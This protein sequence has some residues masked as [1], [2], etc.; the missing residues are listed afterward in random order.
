MSANATE[1]EPITTP[2][3]VSNMA[4][5][6]SC[7]SGHKYHQSLHDSKPGSADYTGVCRA[8]PA[9]E[10]YY[11]P[12]PKDDPSVARWVQKVLAICEPCK[13][14]EHTCSSWCWSN[15]NCPCRDPSFRYNEVRIEQ[16][17]VRILRHKYG[18]ELPVVPTDPVNDEG[19]RA[20]HEL[21]LWQIEVDRMKLRSMK[22]RYDNL[23]KLGSD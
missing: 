23:P 10:T 15:C 5:F 20:S 16:A 22:L 11:Y 8:D 2:L 4:G 17:A 19:L 1:R 6:T 21:C 7:P 9:C 18:I 3:L 14:G 12:V 13:R